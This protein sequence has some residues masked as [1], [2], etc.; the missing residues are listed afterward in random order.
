[1][2]GL[3][4]EDVSRRLHAAMAFIIVSATSALREFLRARRRWR[5]GSDRRGNTPQERGADDATALRWLLEAYLL[6]EVIVIR[7]AEDTF[8]WRG[9]LENYAPARAG[10]TR[11]RQSLNS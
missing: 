4:G 1:M 7:D 3:T 9:L 10:L 5:S 2:S 6:R 11:W 8:L